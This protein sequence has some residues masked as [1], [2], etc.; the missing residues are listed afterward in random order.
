MPNANPAALHR[1]VVA[2]IVA[3]MR[4]GHPALITAALEL[5]A[6]LDLAGVPVGDDVDQ[7]LADPRAA[8]RPPTTRLHYPAPHG[9]TR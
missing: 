5:T 2:H 8:W 7:A 9:G 1:T 3:G 4:S 6:E